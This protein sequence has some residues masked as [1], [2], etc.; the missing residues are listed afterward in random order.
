MN[1]SL[2]PVVD[3]IAKSVAV[4]LLA[5]G[6]LSVW[7]GASASQR[8]L[9]WLLCFSTLL[10]LPLTTL[11]QP[12]WS[13]PVSETRAAV[14]MPTAPIEVVPTTAGNPVPAPAVKAKSVIPQLSLVQLS[15]LIWAVGAVLVLGWRCIGSLRLRLLKSQ[16]EPCD[17]ERARTL[18]SSIAEELQMRRRIELRTCAT[19]SVPMTWG[20]LKPVL[21]L[22]KEVLAWSRAELDAA[23][24]HEMGHIR[25]CDHLARFIMTVVCAVYWFNPLV[26]FAAKRWRTVQ[27][28]ASDDLVVAQGESAESYAMQLLN[29]ARRVQQG[30]LLSLPVMTMAQPSTLE[31]RLSAIMDD[32]RNRQPVRR[33]ILWTS[34]GAAASLFMLCASLQLHA[35]DPAKSTQPVNIECR[36]IECS[37]DAAKQKFATMKLDNKRPKQLTSGDYETLLKE[38]SAIRGVDILSAPRVLTRSGRKASISVEQENVYAL[39]A[40]GK[41]S[42]SYTSG[43]SIELLPTVSGGN[44][45]LQIAPSLREFDGVEMKNGVN[46]PVV[47]ERKLDTTVTIKPGETVVLDGGIDEV[48]GAKRYLIYLVTASLDA[49]PAG[50]GA[51]ETG[52]DGGQLE[53]KGGTSLVNTV[54]LDKTNMLQRAE[55]IIIP[56]VQ[57]REATLSEAIDF[58]RAKA[59]TADP[60]GKGVNIVLSS[61]AADSKALLTLDLKSVPLS[62]ALRYTAA[63]SGLELTADEVSL[64]LR[65]PVPIAPASAPA[66]A[67][68]QPAVPPAK[69]AA[70]EKA[71]R[72]ILPSVKFSSASAAEA[73]EFFRIK[74][75]AA[76]PEKKG[77]NILLSGGAPPKVGQITLELKDV[78]LSEALRYTAE[79][80]EMDLVA[81]EYALFL[82]TRPTQK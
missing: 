43:L 29:A 20:T 14:M 47:R 61:D 8:S 49:S 44:I 72:I 32:S 62:E 81:E 75:L 40:Q 18:F 7:R 77:V 73:V 33:A 45:S 12:R 30:G 3:V 23:L 58:F 13:V 71:E 59:R 28:Q 74:A 64:I 39:D 6:I 55:S 9:V 48:A 36:V 37:S 24:R 17:D 35:A 46:Q 68:A 79:L 65:K 82:R 10:L 19:A 78:P 2:I 56:T 63:L 50:A 67:P 15:V 34:A 53:S 52:R 5:Q 21:L 4:L 25:N 70:L 27:E 76:D 60:S 51:P 57:F 11:M 69:S 31:T 22:P 41:K 80:L 66:A 1:P 54:T 26:W 42:G 38:I 16:T